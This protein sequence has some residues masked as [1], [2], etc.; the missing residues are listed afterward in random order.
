MNLQIK[1]ISERL[2]AEGSGNRAVVYPILVESVKN[3]CGH[4]E[5]NG[6]R[7]GYKPRSIQ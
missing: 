1:S 5:G 7:Y 6:K 3:I 4:R 2:K